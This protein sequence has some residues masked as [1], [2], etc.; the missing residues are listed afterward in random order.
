M[1]STKLQVQTENILPII[2]KWL[3]SERE[4]FLRELLSN[5]L[6]AIRKLKKLSLQEDIR[7][8]EDL[9]YKINISIDQELKAIVIE[10]NGIGMDK[11][12][13]VRYLSNIAFS[14]AHD[15]IQKYEKESI[16]EDASNEKIKEVKDKA[17]IIGN[18][19]LGFYSSFIVADKVEV[20]S[21]SYKKDAD[22]VLWS[23]DGSVDYQLGTGTRDKRGTTI[24]LF[25]SQEAQK[26][27]LNEEEISRLIR[28]YADFVDIPIQVQSKQAN[29]CKPLWI[30]APKE[31]KEEQEYLDF[32]QYLYPMQEK[33]LFHI[34]LNVDYPFRLQGILFFPKLS[35]EVE[36]SKSNVKVYC[37]QV[38]VSDHSH[39]II[40][41]FLSV[42]QGVIDIPDLPLNVSRSYLQS[43]ANIRKISNY[44]INK[45]TD[46]LKAKYTKEREHYD[47]IWPDLAPFV[48]YAMLNDTKFYEQALPALV[49]ELARPQLDSDTEGSPK[50]KNI[51][52][53]DYL[54]KNKEK[55]NSQ[56]F[57]TS[58]PKDQ[59]AA[60]EMLYKQDIDVLLLDN[61]IDSHFIQFLEGKGDG[62][63]FIRIDAE[64]TEH[65]IDKSASS[66]IV[67]NDGKDPA[68]QKDASIVELFTKA[69]TGLTGITGSEKIKVK[70][71]T[72]K[73]AKIPALLV[74]PEQTR[75]FQDMAAAYQLM[76][77]NKTNTPIPLEHTL[78]LNKKNKIIAAM[79][80]SNLV[81]DSNIPEGNEQTQ[82]Q[83]LI[84]RQIYYLARLS[85]NKLNSQELG[86]LMDSSYQLLQD[87]LKKS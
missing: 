76:Q 12:E 64:I 56:I 35:H 36:W 37:K 34:H 7:D 42:L 28:K 24:T 27:F 71:E 14:G 29:H 58:N 51:T 47:N 6:D 39:D 73:D 45:I 46:T 33:P 54:E 66:S 9:D 60:L 41:Q 17:G 25:L 50:T 4:I 40:P 84:A 63:K 3:Y 68:A 55:T 2:K 82:K 62:Y 16:N 43:D 48:K 65:F 38:F 20:D 80:P 23:C 74:Y 13:V 59:S 67:D 79:S 57:Y 30:K 81:V 49:F 22:A 69:L 21:L 8:P 83:E 72:F 31:I 19:G 15:F 11:D 85:Q 75:R 87:S 32:Y 86:S 52:L 77:D 61:I 10:D 26:S 5:S 44:I 53:I 1:S 78:V 70:V 18:F